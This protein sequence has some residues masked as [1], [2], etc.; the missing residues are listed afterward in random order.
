MKIYIFFS[1][2]NSFQKEENAPKTHN[3]IAAAIIQF[4]NRR[5]C[6]KTQIL[7]SQGKSTK[8]STPSHTP[9]GE[10]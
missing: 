9:E 10:I 8:V 3:K 2:K 6:G 5:I 1:R 7:L 4:R